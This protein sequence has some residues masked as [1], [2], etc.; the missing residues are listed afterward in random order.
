MIYAGTDL[1]TDKT[2]PGRPT[3]SRYVNVHSRAGVAT[4]D[5]DDL[6]VRAI[7]DGYATWEGE[8][9]EPGVCGH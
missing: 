6:A 4:G 8:S 1:T 7:E 9:G 5:Q 3:F 2:M